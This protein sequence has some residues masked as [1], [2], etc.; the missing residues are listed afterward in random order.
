MLDA[1]RKIETPIYSQLNLAFVHYGDELSEVIAASGV[2]YDD[3]SQ[4]ARN[5]AHFELRDQTNASAC[6]SRI[7]RNRPS[8]ECEVDSRR[9]FKSVAGF[10]PN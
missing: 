8:F 4:H 3:H 10:E 7:G 9:C 6:S 5:C 1:L 2:R